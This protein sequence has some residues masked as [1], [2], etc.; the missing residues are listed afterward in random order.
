MY[1]FVRSVIENCIF[2][3]YIEQLLEILMIYLIINSLLLG[4]LHTFHLNADT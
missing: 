1:V 3:V 2:V 4:K